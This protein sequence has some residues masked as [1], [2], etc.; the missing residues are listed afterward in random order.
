MAIS[1]ET[2]VLLATVSGYGDVDTVHMWDDNYVMPTWAER[3]VHMWTN[4][5]RIDPS[6]FEEEYQQASTPCSY[7]D[8]SQVNS[9][10]EHPL[11]F[12]TG[13]GQD[14]KYHS[15]DLERIQAKPSIHSTDGTTFTNRIGSYYGYEA[16][17][18]VTDQYSSGWQMVFDF[19]CSDNDRSYIMHEGWWETGVGIIGNYLTQDFGEGEPTTDSRI[20]VG[21]HSP[22]LPTEEVYLYADWYDSQPPEELYAVLD[23]QHLPM[24]L[25][26][27]SEEQ[28]VYQVQTTTTN[29][30][31]NTCH[32]Y[33]FYW[34]TADGDEGAFPEEGSYLFGQ[35]CPEADL[36]WRSGHLGVPGE[37]VINT[38]SGDLMEDIV[39]LGC[40]S[41]PGR[42]ATWPV[43]PL[44]LVMAAQL[45]RSRR[46]H[47]LPSP[48][49]TRQPPRAGR[50]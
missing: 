1:L 47:G 45:A 17:E 16:G 37:E 10:P 20:A 14:S 29:A 24:S 15:I 7:D 28:G 25:L 50:S 23:G 41:L 13:L 11:W 18:I 8:F 39:L 6:A 31:D 19:M 34:K 12:N 3:E 21:I 4:A 43:V 44:V 30:S 46:P 32:E 27:G 42:P 5:V 9:Q 38:K 35:D 26:W 22:E 40:A 33:W 48:E 2:L 36:M 49:E